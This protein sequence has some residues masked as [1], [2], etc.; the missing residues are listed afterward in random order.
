MRLTVLIAFYLPLL[1]VA[2]PVVPGFERFPRDTPLQQMTAGEVLIS[3]LNC[4]A[5][6]A[7]GENQARRFQFRPAPI[8]FTRHNPVSAGW[9]RH[10][11]LDPHKL[12][13]GTLMPD[14]L[15]GLDADKKFEAVEALSHY[16][17]T[18]SPGPVTEK[19]MTGTLSEGKK[20]YRSLGCAQCHSPDGQENG[21]DIPLGELRAKYTHANLIKFL[22][23]PLH[24]RPAGRM[25]RIPMTEQES[26]HIS[27]Y[28][29]ARLKPLDPNRLIPDLSLI[30]I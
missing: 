29:R 15:H 28:L 5:C 12:K 4:L 7:S 25:P 19:A 30:H 14:M 23:D 2:Q 17:M 6:H 3:E 27:T 13:P 11:L 1:A 22:R 8:L 21:R 18:L 9:V 24:S 20:L 16:L 26:A 10:W